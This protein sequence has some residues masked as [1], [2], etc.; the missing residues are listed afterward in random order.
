MASVSKR[1]KSYIVRYTYKN[2]KGESRPGWESYRTEKEAR[3]RKSQIELEQKQGEFLIPNTMTV[4]ELFD[5]WLPIQNTKHRWA[6]KT[7]LSN[8]GQIQD[9]ICPYIGS[10]KVQQVRA[11][12]IEELYR[13]LAKTPC[14]QYVHGVKQTLTPKQQ[15]RLL[16]GTTLN[17]VHGL[18]RT[19]FAYA[20]EWD[21][22][23]KSPIPRD[24][25]RK[26]TNER[27]IW[28]DEEMAAALDDIEDPLLHLAVHMTLVG[29]LRQGELLGIMPQ[30]LDFEGGNGRGTI[31]INKALQRASKA[32]MKECDPTCVLH[33]FPDRREYSTSSL[34]LKTTKNKK[35][36]RVIFMTEPLKKELKSWLEKLV[37]EE[38]SGGEKYQNSGML[39]RM[40]DG[41]PVEPGLLRRWYEKWQA[42]H[43]QHKKIVF[44][45]LRHSSATYQLKVSGGD[46]KSVQGNTG[47]A[48]ANILVNT[49][50]HIQ[51]QSRLELSRKFE[52]DFY[53]HSQAS[54]S[55][56]GQT[57]GTEVSCDLLLEALRN[58][59]PEQKKQLTLALLA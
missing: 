37:R 22:I 59:T 16:S 52:Q 21:I 13:T 30:D 56:V 17:E 4:K 5:R 6:P 1:G 53:R 51:N 46:I 34:I 12:H 54:P 27:E 58:A 7:Y 36:T 55:P 50:A 35:S 44:H 41:Y 9:L 8:L 20:V 19:A 28:D 3:E 24:A 2:E 39:F 38:E 14:G 43:P 11:Y 18:L 48:Q 31:S 33:I 47:H 57:A 40:S 23:R 42:E 15:E 25:P 26:T 29:S 10:M 32:A 49:Y 45:A